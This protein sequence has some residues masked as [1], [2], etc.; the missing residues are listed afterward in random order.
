MSGDT[1]NE[2]ANGRLVSDKMKAPDSNSQHRFGV[3]LPVRVLKAEL[4]GPDQPRPIAGHPTPRLASH[5]SSA[6]QARPFGLQS[7]P[8]SHHPPWWLQ[9]RMVGRDVGRR[10]DVRR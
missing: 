5:R 9:I 1:F 6:D 7:L 8:L 2:H 10:L 4:R 3:G